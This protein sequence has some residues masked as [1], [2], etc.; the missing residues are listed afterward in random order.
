MNDLDMKRLLQR[1]QGMVGSNPGFR[2]YEPAGYDGNVDL[3]NRPIMQPE[4]MRAAYPDYQG[5]YS[6]LYSGT[7]N[8]ADYGYPQNNIINATPIMADGSRVLNDAEMDDYLGSLA[9]SGMSMMDADKPANGGYGLL[10]SSTPVAQGQSLD[11]AYQQADDWT[12]YVHELGANWEQQRGSVPS[13]PMDDLRAGQ[14]RDI[15]GENLR[16]LTGGR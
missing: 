6:T 9:S 2:P 5:D 16:R 15:R 1:R 7:Y 4:Q 11:D 10:M 13:V 14:Y 3:G 8:A 12:Q